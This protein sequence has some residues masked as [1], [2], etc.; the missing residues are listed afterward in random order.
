M[1]DA[2]G[3]SPERGFARLVPVPA[4]APQQL[5]PVRDAYAGPGYPCI[6]PKDESDL[7]RDLLQYWRIA[8]KRMWLILAIVGS[9][10]GLGLTATLMQTPLYT[11][12]VRLQIDREAAKV[13]EQGSIAAPESGVGMEFL[14]TQY[15]L[16]QG[17]SMAERVVAQLQLDEDTEFLRKQGGSPIAWLLGTVSR[18]EPAAAGGADARRKATERVQDAADV[19]PVPNSRLVDVAF[20]HARPELAQKVAN[21]YGD[22]FIAA[23]LDKRFAANAYAKT[24]LEDQLKQLKIRLEESEQAVL[25]FAERE[26][27]VDVTN[28]ASIAENNLSAANVALGTLIS[29]RIRN[30]ELYR[31]VEKSKAIDLPQLLTNSVIDGLRSKRND[32]ATDYQEKLET[33][34]PNYPAMVQLANKVREIDR[35]LAREV[36]TIRSSLKG[37]YQ[38]SLNQEVEMKGRIE[39][40]RAEVLDLQKR[41]ISFNS[42]K[43]EAETNRGLYNSLL[44]RYKEV[45]IA[46]GVGSNNVFIV[47]PAVE[48][49]SPSSPRLARSLLLSLA[50]G[51]ALGLGLAYLMER[52]DDRI[53]SPEEVEQLSGLATLGVIPNIDAEIALELED[54]RSAASEAYRSLATALTFS[55]DSGAPRSLAITSAGPS[56]GKSTTAIAV[57]RHFA[58]MGLKV[59]LIDADLRKPSL[60]TKLGADNSVGLSNYLTGA[61]APP[62]AMQATNHP[63]LAF[64]PS[65][66]LPPNAADLLSGTRI[67]S[68]ISVG[69]EVFDM[70]IL[71][72]PPVMGLA[73]AQLLSNAASATMFVVG[74]GQARTGTLR[75]ALRRLQLT[76]G[77][78]IGSVMTKYDSKA[79]GYGYGYGYGGYSGYGYGYGV[80]AYSYGKPAADTP[81]LRGAA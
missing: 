72:A 41:G 37:A 36:A 49:R 9:A 7:A 75:N 62:D 27:I 45:D 80:E 3:A 52:I 31:Q 63:N 6:T 81:R 8:A 66:P 23:N 35:Q 21:A 15:E 4:A 12:T 67:F 44:Q 78:V 25:H 77:V 58:A 11:A 76:R 22:A 50:L 34:K 18:N 57:A 33:F 60:H 69:L 47:D 48:P 56:E 13:V 53:R 28:K 24:F 42:L 5:G 39:E 74:A 55:T 32:L 46:A 14:K 29:E 30:E 19:K 51:L 20:T 68:L 64:M 59:L 1:T 40:L 79:A 54:P 71:D 70:I 43:H 38:S 73:D 26:Q 10:L 61:V 17:R 2:P 16:L 65:G